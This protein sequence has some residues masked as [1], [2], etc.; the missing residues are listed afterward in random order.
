LSSV[1]GPP[2][3]L[4]RVNSIIGMASRRSLSTGDFVAQAL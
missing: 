2:V 3:W 4:L 1:P